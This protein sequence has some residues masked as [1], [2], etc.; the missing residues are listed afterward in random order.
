MSTDQPDFRALEREWKIGLWVV[1]G[2]FVIAIAVAAFLTFGHRQHANV[3]DQTQVDE[4]SPPENV[5][6]AMNNPSQVCTTALANAK[7][8]GVLP[9]NGRL[10]DPDPRQTDQDNRYICDAATSKSKYSIAIDIVCD[11]VAKASCVSI[12]NIAQDDGS[13]LYQRQN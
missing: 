11:D 10:T 6:D 4:A 8:V 12:Y 5:Q 2:G 7:S 9:G 3:P 1:I 13:V